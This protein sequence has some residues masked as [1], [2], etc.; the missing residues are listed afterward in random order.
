MGT[1]EVWD[2]RGISMS[3]KPIIW[4]YGGGVQSVAILVLVA[5]G[6]LPRPERIVMSDTG[7][8]SSLTW[9]YTTEHVTPLLERLGMRLEIAGHDLSTVDLEGANGDLLIP[10]FTETGKL[11]TFCSTE[12]KRRVI[13]RYL[14]SQGYGP[15]NPVK[16]WFGMSLDEVHRMRVSDVKWIE[17]EYPLCFTVKKRRHECALLITE[18]GLPEPPKSACW[19]CPNRND[20]EWEQQKQDAPEDFAKAVELEQEVMQSHGV[21]L[22]R[23]R[24]PLDQVK[25]DRR[26]KHDPMGLC[27][28]VCWT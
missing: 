17:N 1:T 11:P 28:D 3:D 13:R 7:R 27:S 14:T 23:D 20:A 5:Q 8:E 22:H 6:K 10:A 19:M 25:F 4:S 24:V 16:M 15:A 12:W 21:Y 18:Y 2:R 26:R 9:K